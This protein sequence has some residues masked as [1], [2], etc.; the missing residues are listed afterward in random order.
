MR[1]P[2]LT[3]TVAV[4]TLPLAILRIILTAQKR[5]PLTEGGNVDD[6]PEQYPFL[7]DGGRYD[8]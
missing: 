2:P 6:D 7:T 8:R 4:N 3:R 5:L 1:I